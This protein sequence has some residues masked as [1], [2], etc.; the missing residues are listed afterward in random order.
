MSEDTDIIKKESRINR[1]VWIHGI[2]VAFIGGFSTAATTVFSALVL[3]EGYK[4]SLEMGF[5]NCL[6]AGAM[7]VW[8]FLKQSPLPPLPKKLL[9]EESNL[10]K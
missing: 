5:I 2:G 3:G 1:A 8:S 10:N 4:K 7:T 9:E 6:M